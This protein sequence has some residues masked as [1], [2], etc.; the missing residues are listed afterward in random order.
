MLR[1]CYAPRNYALRS[2]WIMVLAIFRW[3]ASHDK[4]A[5]V[6]TCFHIDKDFW[7]LAISYL[8]RDCSM[9]WPV[10][11]SCANRYPIEACLCSLCWMAC[12][13]FVLSI[14]GQE[15]L[16]WYVLDA[17]LSGRHFFRTEGVIGSTWQCLPFNRQTSFS[18]LAYYCYRDF[19]QLLFF[20]R[21]WFGH[22]LNFCIP[23][24][25]SC[26]FQSLA[27]VSI[28]YTGC[29]L[30]ACHWICGRLWFAR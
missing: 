6:S 15:A 7:F 24:R 8:N 21:C 3:S 18:A 4:F 12:I 16:K 19:Y 9:C 5:T 28:G 1:W 13:V 20:T 29:K 26:C 11:Y 17:C 23:D 14:P 22:R 25:L 27:R 2:F 10:S 30:N